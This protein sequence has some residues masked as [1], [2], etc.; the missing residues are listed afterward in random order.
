VTPTARKVAN[1]EERKILV[2]ILNDLKKEVE[3]RNELSLDVK[4]SD[5]LSGKLR[6]VRKQDGGGGEGV[7]YL[8]SELRADR[9]QPF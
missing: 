6:M 5:G 9:I 4:A 3:D 8:K 1:K 2:C 7:L